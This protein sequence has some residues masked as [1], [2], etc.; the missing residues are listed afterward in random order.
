MYDYHVHS[1]YSDG[2]FLGRMVRAAVEAGLE[3]VGFADHCN[4]SEREEIRRL[5][6]EFGFNLDLTGERRR[7]AIEGLREEYDLRIFDAVEVDYDPR[8]GSEIRA[9]LDE[10]DFEYAVGSV[11]ELRGRNVHWD[12]FADLSESEQR[13]AVEEYFE[14]VVALAESGLFDVAAH[15]D[16]VERNP[17]LRGYATEDQYREVAAALAETGT[18]TEI[19]AGRIGREY[20]EFHPSPEFRTVLA[21]YDVPVVGGTDAHRPEDLRERAPRV[22]QALEAVE[23]E[24]VDL[25]VVGENA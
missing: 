5:T 24:V 2:E 4:V 7:E 8:D 23:L 19:N 17:A 13:A 16:L 9:F 3:G 20:G 11:H 14:K 10:A 12:Y 18:I 21:E 15:L 6:Y 22:E 25:S 1:S